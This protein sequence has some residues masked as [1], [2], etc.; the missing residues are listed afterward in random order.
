MGGESLCFLKILDKS[1]VF[2]GLSIENLT[3]LAIDLKI[4]I[5]GKPTHTTRGGKPY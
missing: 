5:H 3:C 1:P 4:P 2:T